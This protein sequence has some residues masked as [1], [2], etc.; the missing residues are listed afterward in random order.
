MAE[1][2]T[3]EWSLVINRPYAVTA[4]GYSYATVGRLNEALPLL[5]EGLE[6]FRRGTLW[7]PHSRASWL[8]EGLLRLDQTRTLSA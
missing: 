2:L 3:R 7:H 8:G 6:S 4:L 5:V 1:R